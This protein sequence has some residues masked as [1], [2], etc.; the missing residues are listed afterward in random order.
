MPETIPR[1]RALIF[2]L[3]Q[4]APSRREMSPQGLG[5]GLAALEASLTADARRRLPI[6]GRLVGAVAT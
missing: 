6:T 3:V 2:G 4:G 5:C 1:L